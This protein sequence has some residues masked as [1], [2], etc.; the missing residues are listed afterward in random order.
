MGTYEWSG[1]GT[2]NYELPIAN[3]KLRNYPNP[4]N[5]ST[6][7]SFKIS[8]EQNLQNEH[9]EIIV[10]NLKGQKVNTIPITLSGDEGSGIWNGTDKSDQPVSSGIYFAKTKIGNQILTIKM[11]LLK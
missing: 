6:S 2:E 9:C 3:F 7:I 5:P 8:N 11:L 1:V 10:Y 4:F